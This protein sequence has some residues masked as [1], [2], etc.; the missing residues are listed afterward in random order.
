MSDRSTFWK[1]VSA[2]FFAGM[3]I[4][5][6]LRYTPLQRLLPGLLA[7][8]SPTEDDK[9]THPQPA[10]LASV[11]APVHEDLSAVNNHPS[12]LTEQFFT[13]RPLSVSLDTEWPEPPLAASI[14]EPQLV[15]FFFRQLPSSEIPVRP[16]TS[17][18]AVASYL[19]NSAAE[20]HLTGIV[21]APSEPA[22][23]ENLP[24]PQANA[25]K[26]SSP[27]RSYPRKFDSGSAG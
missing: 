17:T 19:R 9:D 2:G 1:G 20:H 12:V 7:D 24:D 15:N 13:P 23:R 6:A 4:A 5:A 18:A 16:S 14:Q 8:T 21:T 11:S 10:L 22:S 26:H 27:L 25:N 3:T